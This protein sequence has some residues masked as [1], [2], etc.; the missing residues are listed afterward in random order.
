MAIPIATPMPNEVK[1]Q[2]PTMDSE[3]QE[4]MVNLQIPR[5]TVDALANLLDLINQAVQPAATSDQVKMDDFAQRLAA[6]DNRI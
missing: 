6:K 4:E 5:S 2:D 3:P 1:M